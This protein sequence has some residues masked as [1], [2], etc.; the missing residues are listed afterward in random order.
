MEKNQVIFAEIGGLFHKNL[1]NLGSNTAPL[2]ALF[3]REEVATVRRHTH[4]SRIE[5]ADLEHHAGIFYLVV[6]CLFLS[7]A[8]SQ[9]DRRQS[10]RPTPGR[11]QGSPLLYNGFALGSI[12]VRNMDIHINSLAMFRSPCCPIDL[13]TGVGDVLEGPLT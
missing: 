8:L 2:T 7:E 12:D 4:Q 1:F 10:D 13:A 6:H 3:Y 5:M 11:P 9:G